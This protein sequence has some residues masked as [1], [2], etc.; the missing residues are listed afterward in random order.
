MTAGQRMKEV[1]TRSRKPLAAACGCWREPAVR[2]GDH[3]PPRT[4]AVET[5]FIPAILVGKRALG[6]RRLALPLPLPTSVESKAEIAIRDKG[7][8]AEDVSLRSSAVV[9][10]YDIQATD[11]S[12]GHVKDFV[13]DDESWAIRYLA[14]DTRN[15]W[16][17]GKKVLAATRWADSIDGPTGRSTPG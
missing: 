8:P 16:P 2:T 4:G 7:V 9:T 1:D 13:F 15:W 11:D 10:G 5:L 12:I 14:V 17:G 3:P 6:D